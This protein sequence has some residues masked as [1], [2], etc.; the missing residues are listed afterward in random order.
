M[1][2]SNEI[3]ALIGTLIR[4]KLGEET[5]NKRIRAIADILNDFSYHEVDLPANV[6]SDLVIESLSKFSYKCYHSVWQSEKLKDAEYEWRHTKGIWMKRTTAEKLYLLGQIKT[7]KDKGATWKEV[8]KQLGLKYAS[9]FVY[10]IKAGYVYALEEEQKLARSIKTRKYDKRD[11]LEILQQIK[12][13]RDASNT[14]KQ[15]KI[16]LKK[17]A[18]LF[19][20]NIIKKTIKSTKKELELAREI[21]YGKLT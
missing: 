4:E 6:I 2:I 7:L 11:K 12:E 3:T 1:L 15:I 13:L 16:A 19:I 17:D 20:Q 18:R 21:Q 9:F 10:R 8:N 5:Y 14:W